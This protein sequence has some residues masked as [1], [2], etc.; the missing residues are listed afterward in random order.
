[1]GKIFGK[2][3]LKGS[4]GQL[5]FVPE[6]FTD[7]I[8]TVAG[9]EW[10]FLGTSLI[11][12]LYFILIWRIFIIIQS[13]KE[14]FAKLIASGIMIMFLFHIFVNIGMTMG[15]MPVTGIPLPFLSYGGSSLIVNLISIGLLLSI[16]IRREKFF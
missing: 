14:D 4:Q 15:I 1:S 11:L 16:H 13:A 10:G 12:F 3:F 2:G 6:H 7:F 8:F 5:N 9:E